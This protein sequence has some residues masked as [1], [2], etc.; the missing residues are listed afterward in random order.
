MSA[1]VAIQD[2]RELSPRA[3]AGITGLCYLLTLVAGI[4][5][6]AFI[7]ERLVV[8]GDAAA[9]ASNIQAQQPLYRLGFTVYLIE[10]AAQVATTVLFYF[11]LKPSSCLTQ[12]I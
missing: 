8:S 10:M 4:I 6:Q 9:T 3:M 12:S 5:A 11:L 2:V 1:A 7:S